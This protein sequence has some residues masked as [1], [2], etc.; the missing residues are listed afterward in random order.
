MSVADGAPCFV[1]ITITWPQSAMMQL[2]GE[3][4]HEEPSAIVLARR[5]AYLILGAYSVLLTITT[6]INIYFYILYIYTSLTY[7]PVVGSVISM[8]IVA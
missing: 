6:Y 7:R 1:I 2:H 3:R 4:R 8:I 5:I